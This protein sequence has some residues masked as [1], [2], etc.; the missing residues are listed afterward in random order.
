MP[1]TEVIDQPIS[2]SIPVQLGE[3]AKDPFGEWSET[4]IHA[5]SQQQTTQQ[6]QQTEPAATTTTT[7][8]THEPEEE[9]FDEATY[10]KNNFGWENLDL[11][12]AEIE[13]LRNLE[14]NPL[15]EEIK[16]ENEESRKLFDLIKQGKVAE[17]R[18]ILDKQDRLERLS[19]Y[20]LSKP[21]QAADILKAHMRFKNP[22]LT[23]QEV[24][25]YINKK[26]RVPAKPQN[27][28]DLTDEENAAALSAWQEQVND[29]HQ[30]M[31]IQAKLV[32]PELVQ[33]KSELILPDIEKPVDPAAAEAQQ[34]ELQ[35][36]QSSRENYLKA[37]ESDFKNFN[38]FNVPYKDED[39]EYSVSFTPTEEE[40]TALKEELK[41][42]NINEFFDKE[43]FDDKGNPKTNR[44]M[45]DLYFL[46]NRD[47]I[48]QKFVHESARQRLAALKK[49]RANITVGT[50]SQGTFQPDNRD[51]SQKQ[52]D[53]IWAA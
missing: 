18:S 48:F 29:I 45:S 50:Q 14:K 9:T 40:K 38:G 53:A 35:Q 16:F 11:G 12:R 27:N 39:V 33:F 46:K 31:V 5:P 13:R 17:V 7:T 22:E 24:D 49:D 28:L 37:L 21:E 25:Y 10:L 4:P 43:W 32:K 2:T 41:D 42:F 44:I 36:W 8:T 52:E 51:H 34:K 23:E 6:T 15:K 26:F 20:D 30:D 47:K 3:N 19:Q 1:D